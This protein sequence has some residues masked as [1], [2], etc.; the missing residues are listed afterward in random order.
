M[1]TSR[2]LAAR[3]RPVLA[4]RVLNATTTSRII[5]SACRVRCLSNNTEKN[6]EQEKSEGTQNSSDN[7]VVRFDD[8]EYDDYEPKTAGQKVESILLTPFHVHI[9]NVIGCFLRN[10][11]YAFDVACCRWCLY[12]LH[13]KRT[14]PW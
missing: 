1:S 11:F 13:R 6:A 10:S 3:L 8:D 14:F 7:K 2:I 9:I 4:S 5:P 12:F